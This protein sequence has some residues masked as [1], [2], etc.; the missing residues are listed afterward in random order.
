MAESFFCLTYDGRRTDFY[1]YTRLNEYLSIDPTFNP[2]SLGW[3][4]SLNVPEI[5]VD[6]F[7]K[8]LLQHNLFGRFPTLPRL[9]EMLPR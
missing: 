3:T 5:T 4:I 6:L 7:R 8:Q 9:L 2:L 1:A